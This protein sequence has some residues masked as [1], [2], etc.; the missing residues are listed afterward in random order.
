VGPHDAIAQLQRLA[1]GIYDLLVDQSD[2]ATYGLVTLDVGK[3]LLMVSSPRCRWTSVPQMPAIYTLTS[4]APFSS[5][6]MGTSWISRG[7]PYSTRTAALQVLGKSVASRILCQ[8][9]LV[10]SSAFAYLSSGFARSVPGCRTGV[11]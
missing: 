6:W 4:M 5:L 2:D 9:L 1:D 8:P 7:L 3:G 11:L 10:L